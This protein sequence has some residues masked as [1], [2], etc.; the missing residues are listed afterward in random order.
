MHFAKPF[1]ALVAFAAPVAL[2]API[3]LA[4]VVLPAAAENRIDTIRPDAPELAAYGNL[5]VGVRTIELTD[6]GR[7][8]V[9]GLEE[10][11]PAEKPA[12]LPKT[13][14]KLT[15]EVFYPAADGA[16]GSNTMTAPMRDGT[17][18]ELVGRSMRDAAVR[19]PDEAARYPLVLISHGYP[20]NRFLLSHLAENL[21]SKGYVVA[22]IDHPASTYTDMRAFGD[23]LLNR[24]ID[25]MFVLGE[26][27]RLG[28]E[29]GSFLQGIVD[30]SNT[31]VIGYSMGGY[32]AL[33]ASGAGITEAGANFPYQNS[34]GAPAAHVQGSDTQMKADPRVKTVVAFGPWGRNRNFWDENGLSQITL[35]VLLIAGSQ[36]DVSGY[37]I[38]VQ[39]I[40]EEMK[41][42]DR[43]LL[44]Y[45][46]ANHNAGAP[47]PA[48]AEAVKAAKEAGTEA[49]WDH[50]GDAVWS[51][52][53]MNNIAQHFVTA[54][55]DRHLKG[56]EEKAKYLDLVADAQDGIVA[57]E[58]DGVTR[59]GEHSYW[60][61]FAPR[62][63]KGLRWERRAAGE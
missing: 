10:A 19:K 40:F 63:A 33:I 56:D 42:A 55:L 28:G 53:R 39:K 52:E 45:E 58:E 50:Y 32:G 4:L 47:M 46:N 41:G 13:D 15:V 35:P 2:A 44:T 62:T 37:E 20:G 57:L 21:A 61:G 34:Y 7:V 60:E 25:Q 48:P 31:G 27:E 14:R 29:E 6:P 36:D 18:V 26:M 49:P 22:S 17:P 24:P 3:A 51:N 16:S 30:A 12:E 38:G 9:A 43:A 1:A 59:K 5:P 11:A 54:W 8:D 23:T